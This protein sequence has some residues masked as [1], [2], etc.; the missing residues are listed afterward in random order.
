MTTP[1]CTQCR[2]TI[3]GEDVNVAN[4]VAF[5][6]KCNLSYRLSALTSGAE[7][8]PNIDVRT[9][10]A[11]AWVR[12]GGWDTVIGATHRSLGAAIA[13]LCFGLFWNGIVSV[14]VLLA[15]SATLHHLDI[16]IP[17]WFPA[18]KM[19]G[20]DMGVSMTLFLWLFLTPFIAIGLFFVGSFLSCLFGRTEVRLRDTQG[21]VFTGIGALGYKR[22]FIATDV[23]EVTIDDRQW[24]DSDGDRRR[25]TA[26]VIETREGRR[27]RFGSM[28]SED[29]RRF[30]ASALRRLLVRC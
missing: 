25:N 3:P 30:V 21:M 4:D 13:M 27:I 17:D 11:G 22:R 23:K 14:F 2:S 16:R 12:S 28:L 5:C 6:R 10:P 9:P 26:I 24:R 29:R 18:P 19:N 15:T 20:G 8:D 1:T 7:L